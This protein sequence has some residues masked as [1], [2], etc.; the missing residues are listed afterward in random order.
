MSFWCGRS[1]QQRSSINPNRN[2]AVAGSATGA[3]MCQSHVPTQLTTVPKKRATP[4]IRAVGR[5]CHR[6]S[7][8][9]ATQ[10]IRHASEM[11][12]GVVSAT[13][14]KLTRKEFMT[15]VQYLPVNL[16]RPLGHL[17]LREFREDARPGVLAK[18]G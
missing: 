14:M 9:R 8:G 7:R 13:S 1:S 12:A 2:I 17:F 4:P 15:F 18:H 11:T 5:Q 16:Q 10:P 3:I 6:S